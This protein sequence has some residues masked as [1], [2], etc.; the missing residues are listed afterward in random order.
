MAFGEDDRSYFISKDVH[1]IVRVI[2]GKWVNYSH[3]KGNVQI[4]K[5]M[6]KGARNKVII[7]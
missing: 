6:S 7:N 1:S 5:D 4:V 3:C 2:M